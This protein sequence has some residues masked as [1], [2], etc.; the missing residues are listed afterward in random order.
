MDKQIPSN[1]ALPRYRRSR[2]I[3]WIVIILLLMVTVGVAW[4]A[5]ELGLLSVEPLRQLQD[6]FSGVPFLRNL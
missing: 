3:W 6:G 1:L 4:L 2:L 5:K